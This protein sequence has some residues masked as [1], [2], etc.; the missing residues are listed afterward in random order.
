[1]E[2]HNFKIYLGG[3]LIAVVFGIL[4][5]TVDLFISFTVVMFAGIYV[6]I[7]NLLGFLVLIPYKNRISI[8][9]ANNKL[10]KQF[11]IN[12][13]KYLNNTEL[14]FVISSISTIVLYG[15]LIANVIKLSFIIYILFAVMIYI[16]IVSVLILIRLINFKYIN[17]NSMY[18]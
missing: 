11:C 14:I 9:E 13:N 16:L 2:K 6:G 4:M 7:I 12:T 10:D 3:L 17:E 15:L 1:M 8:L 5:T 18:N